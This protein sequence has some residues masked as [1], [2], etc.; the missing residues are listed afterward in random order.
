MS[1]ET[2][3]CRFCGTPLSV[4]FVDLGMSP[5][6]NAYVPVAQAR[7]MEPFFP[8][9]AYVCGECLLVQLEEFATPEDIFG[10]YAYFSSFSDTWLEH[11]RTYVDMITA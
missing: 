9:H 11:A 2:A 4:T 7:A 10:N 3:G 5:L 1:A 6:S 8:L